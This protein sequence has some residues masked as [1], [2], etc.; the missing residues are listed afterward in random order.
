MK[1]VARAA[2]RRLHARPHDVRRSR[3]SMGPIGSPIA[4]IGVQITDS[5]YVV[6]N[7]RIMTRMGS[8]RARRA[9]RRRRSCRACTPSACRSSP[10]RPTSPWPCN[11]ED[12]YI[13][14]FPEERAIWS[15]RLAATAATRCSARSASPCASRPCM[16]RDEGWLAEHMLILGVE[17]PDG[18]KT[19]VAAAFPSACGKTNF[20]MLIPP[21][22]VRRRGL[23]G[24]HGRRRHRLD[25]A[26][27]RT[28]GSTRSTPRPASSASP[29]ARRTRPTRTRWRRSATNTI[30]TN[31]ALTDD[32]DVWWE[33]MTDEPPAHADRLAGQRLDARRRTPRRRIRT[34]ASPRRSAQCPSIDPD[35]DDPAGRADRGV[36]L[37]R[38]PLAHG[39]ARRTR[40]S[41]GA[42]GVYLAATMGSETTAAAVGTVGRGAPRPVRDA[43]VLRLPHGRLLQPLAELRPAARRT[44]RASSAST[45]SARTTTAASCGPASARTCAC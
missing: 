41:T 33:G 18:E 6:V 9:R 30:F 5:P 25:Q 28:A 29:R 44:R 3:S 20:A 32:G 8:G 35:W 19:Y 10:A 40:R 4:H 16:A 13:V 39:A 43:A 31:V 21:D 26:G 14:H 23:E 2:V 38:P 1:A 22:G 7:M 42:Y 27:R 34:P 17:S 15:L 24:H 36:R 11:A 12:K 45:G 37:R